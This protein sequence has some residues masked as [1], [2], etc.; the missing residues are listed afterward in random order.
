[1]SRD[2]GELGF[3]RAGED[4]V[5]ARAALHH[6]EEP[7]ISGKNGSGAVF[8]SGCSLRC[9]YCQNAEISLNFRGK[10]VSSDRLREIYSKLV[11][12]GAANINLV[13][14]THFTCAILRSLETPPPVPVI[15]NSSGYESAATLKTLEKKIQIYMPDMKYA[16]ADPAAR[17]SSA[18]DYPETAKAAILEMFRQT[19]PFVLGGDGLLKSGVLIR[20]LILPGNLDNTR[21]VIDWVSGTFSPGDV[22]FS[23]MSQYTP[24]GE[25]DAFPELRAP[26]TAQEYAAAIDCLMAS[27]I[28]DGFYQDPPG[29]GDEASYIPEWDFAGV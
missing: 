17:Y 12:N 13:T 18:P 22:M 2:L 25:L 28:A 19:G 21:A 16:L 7:C 5:I 3:C 6:W 8:F 29:A 20:H 23:L 10:R 9:A 1:V 14:P 4:A 27:E 24:R 11:S 26:I 15:W